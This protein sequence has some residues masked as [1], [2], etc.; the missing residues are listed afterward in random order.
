MI[1]PFAVAKQNY[2]VGSYGPK[3]DP[4]SYVTPVDEAPKGMLAR[5]SY[6]VKSKFLDDDKNVHL[7]WDWSFDIKKDWD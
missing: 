4:H 3:A 1:F 6:K 5:G 7:E 2:M